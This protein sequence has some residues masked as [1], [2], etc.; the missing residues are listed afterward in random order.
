MVERA[1]TSPA[2]SVSTAGDAEPGSR[3][4][5]HF[6]FHSGVGLLIPDRRPIL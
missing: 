2:R 6:Q 4:A 5:V 3:V 1:A